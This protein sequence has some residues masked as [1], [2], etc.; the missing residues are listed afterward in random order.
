MNLRRV[1]T[2]IL[3]RF[4]ATTCVLESLCQMARNAI[5]GVATSRNSDLADVLENLASFY[6]DQGRTADAQQYF[7]RSVAI[8][9]AGSRP[10]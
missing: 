4:L 6:K 2:M 7:K 5:R 3:P 1:N 10:I 8:R 9:K